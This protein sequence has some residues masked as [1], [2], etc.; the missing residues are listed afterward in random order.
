MQIQGGLQMVM[1]KKK[2]KDLIQ[3]LLGMIF[4]LEFSKKSGLIIL[5]K[6]VC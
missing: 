6:D 1:G 4:Q 5:F 2:K 3:R